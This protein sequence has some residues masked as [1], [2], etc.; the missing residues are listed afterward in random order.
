MEVSL[1]SFIMAVIWNSIFIVLLYIGRRRKVFIQSFGMISIIALYGFSAFRMLFPFELPFAA[2]IDSYMIYPNIIDT[3]YH[4]IGDFR[5]WEGLC[6]IWLVIS[7][8][9]ISK[10]LAQ[11]FAILRKFKSLTS[12]EDKQI[13]DVFKKVKK[14]YGRPVKVTIVKSKSIQG[15][16]SFGVITKYILLPDR[17]TSNEGL[18][19]ILS[20]EYTHLKN[21]DQLVKLLSTL[22][23]NLFWWNPLSYLLLKDLEQSLELKCDCHVLKKW[24]VEKKCTYMTAVIQDLRQKK[25][26]Q[27]MSG[28]IYFAGI[29]ED[30]QLKERFRMIIN[31]PIK[32][33]KRSI[34]VALLFVFLLSY[35]F[36]VQSAYEA[37]ISDIE[38]EGGA[39]EVSKD[40]VYIR[41]NENGEYE[42]VGSYGSILISEKTAKEYIREGYLYE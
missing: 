32:Q 5:I 12:P 17:I 41:K 28:A 4:T 42:F 35:A 11:Y 18:Y 25:I 31:P 19:C 33:I 23:C 40:D 22:Y 36:V 37:P 27:G 13:Q 20:H 1:F 14:E 29:N 21:Y 34:L 38:A 9:L 24:S 30:E 10:T 39:Y 26:S 16:M 6:A 15:P 7:L 2:V 3:L 8:F